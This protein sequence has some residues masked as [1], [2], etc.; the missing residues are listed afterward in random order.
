MPTKLTREML[1]E[2][3][4]DEI[5][6]SVN[7]LQEKVGVL[8]YD[9]TRDEYVVNPEDGFH[10]AFTFRSILSAWVDTRLPTIGTP[11]IDVYRRTRF[12]KKDDLRLPN[13]TK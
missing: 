12:V 6:L 5:A 2:S 9:E 3:I 4:G 11:W 8:S 10:Y 7:E 1:N 13:G